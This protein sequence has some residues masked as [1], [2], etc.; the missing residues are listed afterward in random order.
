MLLL[1]L[2]FIQNISKL[3]KEKMSFIFKNLLSYNSKDI[4]AKYFVISC[5]FCLNY[6]FNELYNLFN[7]VIIFNTVL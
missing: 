2:L 5:D 3:L 7:A 6:L 4:L 1:L